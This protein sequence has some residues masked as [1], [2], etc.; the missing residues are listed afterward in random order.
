MNNAHPIERE[1]VISNVQWFK[2]R[3]NNTSELRTISANIYKWDGKRYQVKKNVPW[4]K[5]FDANFDSADK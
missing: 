4:M 1:I 5:R 2:D 3:A